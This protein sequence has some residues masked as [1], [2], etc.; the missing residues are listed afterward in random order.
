MLTLSKS[1]VFTRKFFTVN[2][3]VFEAWPRECVSDETKLVVQELK[4]CRPFSLSREMKST[5]HPLRLLGHFGLVA[6]Y[7]LGVP[8]ACRGKHTLCCD[9]PSQFS[10][11][12]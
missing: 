5:A 7:T 12:T 8:W 9:T 3:F 1:R 4:S 6:L 2:D 11:T 10:L